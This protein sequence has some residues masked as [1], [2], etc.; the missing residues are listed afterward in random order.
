MPSQG[1]QLGAKS[2]IA[3]LVGVLPS[4]DL[5]RWIVGFGKGPL[6]DPD[7]LSMTLIGYL[8][9]MLGSCM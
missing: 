5:T 3:H 2:G 1:L 9:A 6:G 7:A 8:W 4:G